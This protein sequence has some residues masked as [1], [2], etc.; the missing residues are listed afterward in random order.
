VNDYPVRVY[1]DRMR[2]LTFLIVESASITIIAVRGQVFV[3]L[4]L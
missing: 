1:I 4:V 2:A 3:A